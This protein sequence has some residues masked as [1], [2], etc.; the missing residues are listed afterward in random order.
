MHE[1]T[2]PELIKRL[3]D[4]IPKLVDEMMKVTTTFLSREVAVSNQE[5]KETLSAWKQQEAAIKQ[6]FD[7]RGDFRNQ[8]RSKRRLDKFTLFTKSPKEILA[9]DE[10]KFKALP[11]MTTLAPSGSK[12][13]NGS[14]YR[15][16]HWLQWRN[17]RP[18]GQILLP[19]KIRDAEH[20]TYTWMNF[21]VV[22]SQSPYNGI[23]GRP[24]VRKIQAVPSTAHEMLKFPVPGGILTLRSSMIILLKCTLV[25]GPEAQP[26]DDI[27]TT[28]ERIKVAICYMIQNHL[29]RGGLG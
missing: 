11:P 1:I 21:V 9:L 7:K 25:S 5:R 4:N 15:T 13:P 20:F 16:P 12:K 2:N 22:R 17:Y 19:V 27:Q 14:S 26:S 3:H 6:N 24:K 18:M 8:E 23:I 29:I 28:K 10:G